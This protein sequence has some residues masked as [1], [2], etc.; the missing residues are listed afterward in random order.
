MD[1]LIYFYKD[2]VFLFRISKDFWYFF[3]SKTEYIGMCESNFD[4][5]QRLLDKYLNLIKSA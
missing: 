2:T 5:A 1:K 4:S 3:T